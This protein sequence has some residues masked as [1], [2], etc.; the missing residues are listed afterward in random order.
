MIRLTEMAFWA[1]VDEEKMA[2]QSLIEDLQSKFS[3]Q[4]PGQKSVAGPRPARP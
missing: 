2:S 4:P 3:S 1:R